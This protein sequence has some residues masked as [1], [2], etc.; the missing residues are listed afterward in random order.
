MFKKFSWL[1]KKILIAALLILV[2][3]GG[4]ASLFLGFLPVS[5]TIGIGPEVAAAGPSRNSTPVPSSTPQDLPAGPSPRGISP[6]HLEGILYRT[7]E[8]IINLADVGGYRYLR[9]SIVLEFAPPDAQ[10]YS[11]K[12]EERTAAEEA[13][14][15]RVRQRSAK[16]EDILTMT[17]SSKT[18]ADVFSTEGKLALKE[19]IRQRINETLTDCWVANVYFTDFV[20]Q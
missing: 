3:V 14:L 1:N 13:F 6:E 19:E 17:L 5:I 18:F 20:I 4:A 15:E 8:R 10:F 7:S 2:L 9:I 11:L 16:I 12:G